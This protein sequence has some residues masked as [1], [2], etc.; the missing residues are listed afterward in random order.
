MSIWIIVMYTQK[1]TRE[2]ILQINNRSNESFT[3]AQTFRT[4]V[5][6]INYY[7]ESLLKEQ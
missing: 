3:R 7:K 4:F 5:E 2:V 1:V 6:C